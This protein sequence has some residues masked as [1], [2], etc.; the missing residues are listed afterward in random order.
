MNFGK[1]TGWATFLAIF[2]TDAFGHPGCLGTHGQ[3][4]KIPAE[5][6]VFLVLLRS[7]PNDSENNNKNKINF[8]IPIKE[9]FYKCR[10]HGTSSC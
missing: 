7:T 10:L 4:K 2:F 5:K 3:M 1:A 6:S 9:R 8:E